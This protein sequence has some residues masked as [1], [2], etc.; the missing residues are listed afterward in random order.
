MAGI[1]LAIL[2]VLTLL[3]YWQI[4][5][6]EGTYLGRSIVAK[7]YDWTAGRY[8]RIKAYDIDL[9]DATLGRPLAALLEHIPHPLVLDVA[10]GTGRVPMSLLRQPAFRGAVVGL[11]LSAGML[12]QARRNLAEHAGR[13]LLVRGDAGRLPFPDAAFH[14]VVCCEALEFMPHPRRALAEM[15]RVL[16]PGGWLLF[17]NRIGWEARFLPGK[18][19]PR[20]R[21]AGSL[22]GL[23][24]ENVQEIV[25]ETNYDQVWARRKIQ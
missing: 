18:V 8:D 21:V 4:I 23:P 6:A 5:L 25:W 17:T 12:T 7:L 2:L 9:E 1:L 10:T 15:T 22:Q 3:I 19:F 16:K 11:D 20:R 24:L 14:A 13:V